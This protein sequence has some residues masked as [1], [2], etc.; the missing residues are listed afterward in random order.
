MCSG[1]IKKLPPSASSVVKSE[2]R[3]FP[4]G[5]V[6]GEHTSRKIDER[7]PAADDTRQAKSMRNRTAAQLLAWYACLALKHF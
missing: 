6:R 7:S 5:Q 4:R 1:A 3:M 2:E